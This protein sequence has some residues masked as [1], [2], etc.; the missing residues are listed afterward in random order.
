MAKDPYEDFQEWC[1]ASGYA[2]LTEG[3]PEEVDTARLN[4]AAEKFGRA[5]CASGVLGCDGEPYVREC[6]QEMCVIHGHTA[7]DEDRCAH[8]GDVK[9]GAS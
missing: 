4:E 2:D 6:G 8:S 9:G 7:N 1:I 3:K 5:K